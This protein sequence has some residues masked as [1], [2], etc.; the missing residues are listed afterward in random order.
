MKV[1]PSILFDEKKSVR[2][3]R[4]QDNKSKTKMNHLSIHSILNQA[5]I[6]Q[7]SFVIGHQSFV[8]I[9]SHL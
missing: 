7:W 1:S 3:S 2:H 5:V 8:V 6:G 4:Q 9:G